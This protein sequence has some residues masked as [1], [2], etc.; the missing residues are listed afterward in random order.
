MEYASDQFGVTSGAGIA[1]AYR[2]MMASAPAAIAERGMRRTVLSS[3]GHIDESLR[4]RHDIEGCSSIDLERDVFKKSAP[5]RRIRI[6]TSEDV[7]IVRNNECS[8]IMHEFGMA[9]GCSYIRLR[10]AD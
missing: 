7:C 4:V 6:Q 3:V 1:C 9:K 5:A 2:G 10:V 8:D